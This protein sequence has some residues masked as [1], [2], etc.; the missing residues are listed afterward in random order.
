MKT[1][2]PNSGLNQESDGVVQPRPWLQKHYQEKRERTVRLVKAAVDQLV[3]EGQAVTI[4][5]ICRSS[6]ELDPGGRGVKKSALLENQEAHTYYREHSASYQAAQARK[7]QST[8]KNRGTPRPTQPLHIDPNRNVERV[9]YRYRQMNKN[10]L[11]EPL[12][13]V[14][15][16]YAAVQ[17]QLTQLQFKLFE[18]EQHQEEERRQARRPSQRKGGNAQSHE[19]TKQR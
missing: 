4:E 18:Q 5:A 2:N 3:K 7:R 8:R 19:G 1:T 6:V 10:D 9:R 17:Q 13:T 11:V 12:L 15:Q 14:E 16:G